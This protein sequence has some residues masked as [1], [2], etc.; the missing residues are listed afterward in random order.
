MKTIVEY[1]NAGSNGGQLVFENVLDNNVDTLYECYMG[2]YREMVSV[3]E[4]FFS[5]IG[6]KIASWGN[7]AAAAGENMDRRID[8][9][10]DS[11]KK[12]I[13]TAKKQAGASWDKVKDAYQSVVLSVDD[14][15]KASKDSINGICRQAKLNIDEFE[16]KL[17]QIYTNAIAQS[18]ESA[19]EMKQWISDKTKGAQKFAAMNTLLAGAMMARN[20]GISSDLALQILASAGFN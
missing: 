8:A 12:A 4:G 10:S 7:K 20:A 3:N 18:K 14:A 1:M 2:I 6:K 19:E 5:N 9:A 17:G 16:A 11:A 13:Y 15:I